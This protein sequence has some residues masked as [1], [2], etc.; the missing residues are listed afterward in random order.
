MKFVSTR[1]HNNPVSFTDAMFKGL[2]PDGGLYRPESIPDL[3]RFFNALPGDVPFNKLASGLTAELLGP[4]IS[5]ETAENIIRDAFNFEPELRKIREGMFV[6]ELF[7]GPSCAFKDF[8]ASFLASAMNHLLAEKSGNDERAI[9]VTATS[10]DTGSAVARAFHGKDRI[11]VVI[12]YPS[13]RVSPLQ[14]KQLTTLG[15]N[16][17]ALEVN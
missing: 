5:P 6:L 4:E 12:L 9:I 13:G 1:N 16:V 10:G 2:A 8:G 7:H 17:T 11:D 15:G 3:S 14:E